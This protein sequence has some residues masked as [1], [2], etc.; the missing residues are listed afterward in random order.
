MQQFLLQLMGA[1]NK[2]AGNQGVG[3]VVNVPAPAVIQPG[4]NP[5]GQPGVNPGGQPVVNQGGQQGVN[6]GCPGPIGPISQPVVI[7]GEQQNQR[8]QQP[9]INVN[10]LH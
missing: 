4:G 5:G 1:V 2:N 10:C 3:A 6:P 9:Q 7:Q 8:V